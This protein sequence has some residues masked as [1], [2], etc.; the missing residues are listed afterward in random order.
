VKILMT[1]HA[2]DMR[3]GSESYLQTVSA[4]LRRLGHEVLF[5]SP[6][7]GGLASQLRDE[8]FEVYDEASALPRDV[9][10][11]H[12]Q[13]VDAV[14]LARTR[15]GRTP[16]VFASH[17]W[18]VHALEDPVAELG[19]SAYLAFN[20]LVHQRL[21]TSAVTKGAEVVRLTQP[22][23]ISHGDSARVP[24]AEVPR[25]AVAVSRRMK[26]LPARLAKACAERGIEFEWIG[27]A[28]RESIDA[29][30]EMFASDIVVAIGRTAVE[31]MAAGRAV[32]VTDEAEFGGWVTSSSYARLEA[33]GFT[34]LATNDTSD[35]LEAILAAYQPDLGVVA[36]Q[37][38]VQH[39]SGQLH[40][41]RLVET[42]QAVAGASRAAVAPHVVAVLARERHAWEQR[43]LRAEWA[44]AQAHRE[45]GL[46]RAELD[47]VRGSLDNAL[48]ELDRVAAVHQAVV[49][50]RDRLVHQRNRLREQ[51]HRL[52]RQRRELRQALEAARARGWWSLAR[53]RFGRRD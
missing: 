45:A 21:T 46:A 14:A 50:Q 5:F 15:L 28:G 26:T 24:I 25:R 49:A 7:C 42:Y 43:V 32:L 40:A 13:H 47:V 8:G 34:G 17:S 6:Q 18:F 31:A 23:E 48:G 29:R 20:D 53:R 39:H 27:E 12:G 41:A 33:D 36:R 44:S 22:V 35:D 2:L 30:K 16:L 3:A 9:D 38:A 4:E 37:L 1:N 51:R 11:I 52:R 10:V 19:A